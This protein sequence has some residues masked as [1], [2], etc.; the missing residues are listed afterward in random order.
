[1]YLAGELRGEETINKS[2][3]FIDA[4]FYPAKGGGDGVGKTKRGK[5]SKIMVIVDSHV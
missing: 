4:M 5:G 3:S 2:G 1:M